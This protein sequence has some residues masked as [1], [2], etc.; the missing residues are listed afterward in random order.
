MHNNYVGCI[1]GVISVK[2]HIMY[3]QEKGKVEVGVGG[4]EGG[5]FMCNNIT[6]PILHTAMRLLQNIAIKYNN[7]GN[8]SFAIATICT[9]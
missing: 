2:N 5:K 8:F 6:V 7:M 4:G 3:L 9:L 1:W